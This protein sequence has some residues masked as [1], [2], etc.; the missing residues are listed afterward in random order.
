MRMTAFFSR[1]VAGQSG[2]AM[3]SALLLLLVVSMLAVGVSMD[4]SMDVRLAAYQHFKARSLGFA[5]AGVMAA[6]DILEENIYESGWTNPAPPAPFAF[7]KLSANYDGTINILTTST[8]PSGSFYL[9]NNPNEAPCIEMTGDIAADIMIQRVGSQLTQGSAIQL[10][11]GYAAKGKGAGGG[12]TNVIFNV[13]S[14]GV[15]ADQTQSNIGIYFRHV[16][17]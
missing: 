4:T 7:P 6:T 12:G 13:I 3:I 16:T 10:A 11:K 1:P 17:N 14:T 8:S 15:D 9:D 2:M 5:E